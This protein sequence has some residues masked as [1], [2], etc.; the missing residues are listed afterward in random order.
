[1]S[2]LALRPGKRTTGTVCEPGIELILWSL[3][4]EV[5]VADDDSTIRKEHQNPTRGLQ[6]QSDKLQEAVAR[7]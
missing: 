3:F 6:P 4:Q 1:M 2:R 7:L 5:S